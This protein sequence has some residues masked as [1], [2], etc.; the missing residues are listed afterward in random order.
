MPSVP[1]KYGGTGPDP[2]PALHIVPLRAL[3]APAPPAPVAPPL[4]PQ[5]L[6]WAALLSR[7]P[8]APPLST[9]PDLCQGHSFLYPSFLCSQIGPSPPLGDRLPLSQVVTL[10]GDWALT[11][12]EP[13]T[14]PDLQRLQAAVNLFHHPG[15]E[16][17]NHPTSASIKF[18]H[19]PTVRPDGS[20]VSDTDLL[21]A[22]CSHPHW[23]DV[24]FISHPQFIQSSGHSGDLSAL[25]HC[26]VCD[27]RT[28]STARSLLKSMVNFFGSY[29]HAQAWLINRAAPFCTTCCQ[30]GHTTHVCRSRKP[31]CTTCTGPHLSALHSVVA[32]ADPS[33]IKIKCINC[34]GPHSATSRQCPFF[35]HHFNV[36]ALAE[37]QK[38]WLHQIKEAQTSKAVSKP[39]WPSKGKG[40]A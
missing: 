32:L 1:K 8:P 23:Q 35:T 21:H 39:A 22:I 11:F 28:S 12:R 4:A 13:L 2:L 26:E 16:V 15:S 33:Y 34:S 20:A 37:L 10:H 18:P 36:P 9:R 14:L 25:V 40:K 27:S 29:C 38:V 5:P 24:S 19:V 7:A 6:P 17:V 3:E 30:W 31:W